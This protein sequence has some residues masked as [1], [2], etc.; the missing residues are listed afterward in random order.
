MPP[1][2]DKKS[3]DLIEQE[4]RIFLATS[5][6]QNGKIPTIAEGIQ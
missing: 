4:G 6:F 1:I 3:K 2:R 5:D